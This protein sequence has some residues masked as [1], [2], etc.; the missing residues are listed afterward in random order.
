MKTSLLRVGLLTALAAFA[1]SGCIGWMG[2]GAHHG[3]DDERGYHRPMH[4]YG[5]G[6]PPPVCTDEDGRRT[7]C[8]AE[9]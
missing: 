4:G 7:P 2:P 1:L 5:Y 3:W 9:R 8:P 6:P